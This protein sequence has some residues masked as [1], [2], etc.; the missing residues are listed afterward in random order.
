M[1]D[2]A[3]NGRNSRSS[4]VKDIGFEENALETDVG[5]QELYATRLLVNG[6]QLTSAKTP[7]VLDL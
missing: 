5:G 2:E 4:V 1:L 3:L 7:L 6:V